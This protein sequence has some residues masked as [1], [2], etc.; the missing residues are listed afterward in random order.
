[1][2]RQE[3]VEEVQCFRCRGTEHCKWEC[4][5]IAVE[6]EKRRQK[7]AVYPTEGKVQQWE[8]ARKREPACSN[9][10]KA[11][12]YCEMKDMPKD[13]RLLE[14]GWMTG[15]VIV[16]YIECRWCRKKGIYREDNIEQGVLK[17]R[18]LEEAEWCRCPKQKRKEEEAACP[19]K[20]KAQQGRAQAEGTAR[21]VR[22]TF[23]ILREVWMDIGI[24]K[25]DM[26]EGITV[27]ALLDSG[28]TGMFMD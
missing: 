12:E 19:T 9:W 18:K 26:H 28:T 25:V 11:Q 21:E 5:N 22:R 27:K 8:K 6:K 14:L 10:E 3:V 16:T 1:M 24:E 2:R 20:G 7:E 13:A 23:K 4:P 15:E 17:G